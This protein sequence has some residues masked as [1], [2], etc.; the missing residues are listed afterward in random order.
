MIQF[1]K[2]TKNFL[3]LFYIV[4]KYNIL[5]DRKYK[6]SI[7]LKIFGYIGVTVLYPYNL[8]SKP[9]LNFGQR[10][11]ELFQNLGPIYI[12]FGQ[13][14]STRPDLIGVEIAESLKFLQDK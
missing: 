14:L 4:S 7:W 8:F 9:K 12:K 6:I 5:T 3:K 10:L 2:H 11:A 13:T 1:V